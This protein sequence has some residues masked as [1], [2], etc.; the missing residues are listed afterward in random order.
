MNA[1]ERF[2][3]WAPGK[4][5]VRLVIGGAHHEMAVDERGWW[6]AEVPGT[7]AGTDYAFLLDDDETPLPDPRS[8]WQPEG[9]HGP[10]RRYEHRA[11]EW[12]DAGWTGKA[13]PGSVLY[14]L[15]IGTFTEEG[16]FNAAIDRL[17]HLVELGV[18]LVKVLP[19]NAFDGTAGWGYDGVLWG[20]V[21]QPYGGPTAFKQFVDACHARGLGVVLDVVYNHLGP[22]GAYLDRFG[23]YFAGKNI[24]G[25]TLNL[26]G[27]GSDEV[28]RYVLDNAL[29]WFRDY[30][31]DGLR[32][33]AV[34]ALV[35]TR[36][37]PLL[38]ELA[39]EVDALAT[40]LGRPLALIAESDLNDPRHV[41]PRAAG[42]FGLDAQWCDDIH[43]ALHVALTGETSGYY[44][45]F[46]GGLAHTLRSAFFHAGTWSSFRQRSHGRPVDKRTTSGHRFLAYLQ[47]HDQIG[48]RATGDRLTATVPVAR[49]LCG[50]AL[51]FCSPYT[52]MVFMGE[53]W[54]AGTPWQF[55]AS[56]PDPALAE[57]V[58]TGRRRE[59]AEHGWGEAEVPDPMD[60]AT[61]LAS[62][63]NWGELADPAHRAVF[64]TYRALIALRR[65]HPELSDPRL[66]KFLVEEGD[67]W[68]LLHRG[69]FRVAV[70]LGSREAVI[71]VL[72]QS[73]L[74]AA[75]GV[76]ATSEDLRLPPDTFAVVRL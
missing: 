10:S 48:N 40:G 12:T 76:S 63:L 56:F 59:F 5:R 1:D 57:A 30:H 33:D 43:H 38:E 37:L 7:G 39:V 16:T 46:E 19:V 27:P 55:F 66:D 34:H 50:A 70:N 51:V 71:P 61:A 29:G 8:P 4:S 67:G 15:H 21:H 41:T 3:V 9:V 60:P 17:D 52:P 13:L 45:D 73:I 64:D 69:A 42:G 20:A 14:E 32:L 22:S 44:K 11:F 26:D 65:A 49:V 75:E 36:A 25:P 74:L 18:D 28:R 72:A 2:S 35:D 31:V 54:A 58:R 6:H 23:P 68:L 24:W 53:E 62:T 47:N